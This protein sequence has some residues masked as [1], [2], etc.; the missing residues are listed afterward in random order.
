MFCS[1]IRM[2]QRTLAAD[3]KYILAGLFVS[4]LVGCACADALEFDGEVVQLTGAQNED[5]A[6]NKSN[7]GGFCYNLSDT[8]CNGAETLTIA[9]GALE[10]PN[11]DRIIETNALT[12]TTSL[13]WQ[14]YEL[15][16]NLGLTV[17]DG[18]S[19]GSGYWIEFWMGEMYVAIDGN[20]DKLAKPLVEF[21]STDTKT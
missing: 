9:D 3:M 13:I 16:K 10:G 20:A 18:Y 19:G 17:D 8:A 7:F 12:Y 15:H 11:F 6:W 5:I 14:E 2:M 4:I 1:E 21:N